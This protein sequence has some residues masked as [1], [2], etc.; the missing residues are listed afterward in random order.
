MGRDYSPGKEMEPKLE[1]LQSINSVF[2]VWSSALDSIEQLTTGY[3]KRM[4]K[5]FTAEANFSVARQAVN[6]SK[7]TMRKPQGSRLQKLWSEGYKIQFPFSFRSG[8]VDYREPWLTTKKLRI[9]SNRQRWS[10]RAGEFKVCNSKAKLCKQENNTACGVEPVSMAIFEV[11]SYTEAVGG[12]RQK[13]DHRRCATSST[14]KKEELEIDKR[15]ARV[16]DILNAGPNNRFTVSGCL[17][18]NC[19]YGGSVGALKAMGALEQGL[20]ED[21]LQPLVNS[22]RNSNPNIVRFW[23]AVDRA[24]L[25]AVRNR[26]K[27]ETHGIVFEFKSGM[28]FVTLPSGRNL[29][30]VKPIIGLNKFDRDCVTYEGIGS[31]NKW[32]RIPTYGPKLVEN[33]V[34]AISRDLLCEAMQKLIKV[35]HKIV[36]HI[37]DEVVIEAPESAS[38]V[39]ICEVMGEVPDW[40]YGLILG[41][42]GFEALFYQKD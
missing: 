26:T 37:H 36:M 23:W 27:T 1:S 16:Y 29:S 3:L 10:L 11:G 32:E 31:A 24:A 40:A 18:H 20:T 7:T 6:F 17:V 14:R 13:R 21:E 5:M 35:G 9:R 28:L 42:D 22:W 4:S 38:L 8:F 25:T 41:A 33:I 39:E 19:G 12:K 2:R 15:K 34:Q 30:Y